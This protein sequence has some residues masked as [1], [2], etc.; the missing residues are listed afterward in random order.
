MKKIIFILSLIIS[1]VL[2]HKNFNT[3]YVKIM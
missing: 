1:T 3:I 2:P